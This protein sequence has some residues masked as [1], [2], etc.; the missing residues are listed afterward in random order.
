MAPGA[1]S[2]IPRYSKCFVATE[3]PVS[4]NDLPDYRGGMASAHG[5]RRRYLSGCRCDLCTEEQRLHMR[6]YRERRAERDAVPELAGPG[7]VELATKAQLAD[8][9]AAESQ[10]G[11]AAIAVALAKVLDGRIPTPKPAAARQLVRVLDEL[12]KA[13]AR[14]RRGGLALV[15]AMTEKGG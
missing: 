3:G 8:L 12:H 5:T 7:A 9:S 15:K 14:T 10:P 1:A 13:S 11:L 2:V 6:A 4:N